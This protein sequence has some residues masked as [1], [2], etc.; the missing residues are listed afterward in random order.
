MKQSRV[1]LFEILVLV[2]IILVTFWTL[3][4]DVAVLAGI[5]SGLKIVIIMVGF[6]FDLF[7][8]IEFLARLYDARFNKGAFYYLTHGY[9][10]IDFFASVP[11]LMLSS[12]PQAVSLYLTMNGLLNL[13]AL[14][15]LFSLL[16][17]IKIIRIARVLRL[18]RVLKIFKNIKYTDTKMGQRHV[19]RIITIGV[20]VVIVSLFCTTTITEFMSI[21]RTGD[22]S[23]IA[24]ERTFEY[25]GS[26]VT[27]SKNPKK[28]V[29]ELVSI[30]SIHDVLYVEM[31]GKIVYS[32]SGTAGSPRQ[33]P[34]GD[35]T[36]F[37]SIYGPKTNSAIERSH[38]KT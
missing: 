16:K 25:I 29:S 10:W 18:L 19:M 3:F 24:Q 6:G 38:A 37:I 27:A 32:R 17:L 34:L 31:K 9:G 2:M 36:T 30:E 8:T 12:G 14:A 33:L 35:Y 1:N 13:G 15:S 5:A 20:T 7:F 21:A 11:L 22:P 28:A 26:R 4:E 23:S